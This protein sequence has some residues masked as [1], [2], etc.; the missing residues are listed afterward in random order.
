LFLLAQNLSLLYFVQDPQYHRARHS[1]GAFQYRGSRMVIEPNDKTE[2][3][4]KPN[5]V[6]G[7]NVAAQFKVDVKVDDFVD[8]KGNA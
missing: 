4:G 1:L 5:G 2:P 3:N 6:R 8:L 7:S